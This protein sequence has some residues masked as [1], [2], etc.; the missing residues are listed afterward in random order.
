MNSYDDDD[1]D[2]EMMIY[3]TYICIDREK[4]CIMHRFISKNIIY[5]E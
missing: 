5:M 2:D 3:Y 1:D 4:V